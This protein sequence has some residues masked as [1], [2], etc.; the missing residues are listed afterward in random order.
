MQKLL[1][2]YRFPWSSPVSSHHRLFANTRHTNVCVCVTELLCLCLGG[3]EMY[4]V[5]VVIFEGGRVSTIARLCFLFVLDRVIFP[6]NGCEKASEIGFLWWN[7]RWRRMFLGQMKAAKYMRCFSDQHKILLH[8]MEPHSF[9]R[10][11]LQSRCHQK[12]L[13]AFISSLLLC[14]PV[15]HCPI[16]CVSFHRIYNL[17]LSRW[18]LSNRTV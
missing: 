15:L 10:S 13:M 16:L 2:A 5:K 7:R 14:I 6:C 18:H 17:S 12:S 3:S 1:Q 8:V 4:G 9:I 11:F